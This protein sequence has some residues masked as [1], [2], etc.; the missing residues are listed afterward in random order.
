MHKF[1]L[2][3]AFIISNFQSHEKLKDDLLNIIACSDSE[4][5]IS[6]DAEVD[7]SRTDWNISSNFSRS[8]VEY[9]VPHLIPKMKEMYLELGYDGFSIHEIWFQQY[10][11]NSQHGWHTHSANFTN[12]YYLELPDNSP[13]TQI[14]NAFNQS[15]IIELDVKEG[16]IVTFPSFVIHRAPINKSTER[17]TIISYNTNALYSDQMY[18]K[19][20]KTN[21]IF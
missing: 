19:G 15:E 10:R 21:A 16:D 13:R 2:D 17:K 5:A 8:W 14:V 3:C 18:G 6:H 20:L 7:I 4:H 11:Q 12:V 1:Q 9:F